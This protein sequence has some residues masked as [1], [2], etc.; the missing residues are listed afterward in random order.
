MVAVEPT[1]RAA[2]ATTT[3]IA[4]ITPMPLIEATMLLYA[5]FIFSHT[6]EAAV[7]IPPNQDV[8]FSAACLYDN[9]SLKSLKL[10]SYRETL[11][12]FFF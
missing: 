9:F 10:L 8:F 1:I 5:D 7:L 6:P 4:G 12:P 3:T 11:H 2:T